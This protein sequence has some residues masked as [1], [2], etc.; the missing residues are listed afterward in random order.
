MIRIEASL[1]CDKCGKHFPAKKGEF[2]DLVMRNE[3]E[4]IRREGYDKGWRRFRLINTGPNGDYCPPCQR[5]I[6]REKRAKLEAR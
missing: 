6:E 1:I 2:R 3:L 5:A 4:A